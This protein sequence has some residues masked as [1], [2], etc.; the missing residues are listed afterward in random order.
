[1]RLPNCLF[2]APL[3]AGL[4]VAFA[5]AGWSFDDATLTVQAK[6][7]GVGA[8]AKHKYVNNYGPYACAMSGWLLIGCATDSVPRQLYRSPSR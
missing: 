6:G 1:M 2:L 5:A 8:G 3:L 4:N 7:E